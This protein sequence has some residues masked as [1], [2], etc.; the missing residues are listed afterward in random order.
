MVAASFDNYKSGGGTIIPG[1]DSQS[2]TVKKVWKLDDGGK[3]SES[4][5]AVLLCNGQPYDQVVLSEGNG[6][7]Y[8]W[9]GLDRDNAWSVEEM[10]I[11]EGFTQTITKNGDTYLIVNDDEPTEPTEPVEPIDPEEPPTPP[12]PAEP[13]K[14][15]VPT[16]P[17]WTDIEDPNVP[18]GGK[19]SPDIGD[20]VPKTGDS[21][22]I[23]FWAFMTAFSACI[24]LALALPG[25]KKIHHRTHQ[26]K[27][28]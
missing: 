23:A 21:G 15:P 14:P 22:R 18:Q 8:T 13:T 4:V 6:W 16:D 1:D 25:K 5:T 9:N 28:L 20:D 12:D 7:A 2:I 17:D 26:K 10:D 11:P 19:D 27:G 24:L 3:E